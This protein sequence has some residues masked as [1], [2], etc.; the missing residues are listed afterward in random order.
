MSKIVLNGESFDLRGPAGPDGNP[1][2]TVISFMGLK[3]PK[4]YL[5]CDGS[6]YKISDYPHLASFFKD[7]FD[8]ETHF[9]SDGK[10]TFAVPD[11]R[12]LFLR[13][14]HGEADK[15]LSGDVG[16]KQDGTE[17]PRIRTATTAAVIVPLAAV[18]P[19]NPDEYLMTGTGR[20][21][22]KE[23]STDGEEIPAAYTSRPV[24][25]AVLYC[26]K[27]VD[28]QT[29]YETFEEYDTTVDGCDWHVRKWSNGYC[30]MFGK[31]SYLVN[32]TSNWDSFYGDDTTVGGYGSLPFPFPMTEIYNEQDSIDSPDTSLGI[33]YNDRTQLNCSR[34][35]RIFKNV[36]VSNQNIVL[37][38]YITGRWK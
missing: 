3:A 18:G 10:G 6:V 21:L 15:R 8:S 25:M 38:I 26:I 24:N 17:F 14:Y 32:V 19:M 31:K 22:L 35:I 13:G 28:R 7:Q 37:H 16:E 36:S 34:S 20:K 11:M 30:E 27:A 4:E 23:D 2:G 1:I 5:V 9:G 12:N 33:F 29:V